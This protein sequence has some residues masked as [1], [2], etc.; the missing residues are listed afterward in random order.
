MIN[1]YSVIPTLLVFYPPIYHQQHH[2]KYSIAGTRFFA[3]IAMRMSYISRNSPCK[4]GG[5]SSPDS[6]ITTT[7]KTYPYKRIS[8]LKLPLSNQVHCNRRIDFLLLVF[9]DIRT[10]D[11]R[12]I[13]F[14]F[15]R[16]YI[17]ND[18]HSAEPWYNLQSPCESP[19]ELRESLMFQ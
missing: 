2:G 9:K 5:I 19:F 3:L 7:L 11:R 10:D 8:Q 4:V 13:S 17:P 1:H 6:C 12:R 14:E 16:Q 15:L 18:I